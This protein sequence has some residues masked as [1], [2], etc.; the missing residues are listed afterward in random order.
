ME[1]AATIAVT[2]ACNCRQARGSEFLADFNFII[3]HVS[4]QKNAQADFLSHQSQY[5]LHIGDDRVEQQQQ[6][7]LD[8]IEGLCL[9]QDR[10]ITKYLI[11]LFSQ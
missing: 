6:I 1:P 10:T 4:G 3:T 5:Q 7:L 2:L 11:R 9:T 8:P